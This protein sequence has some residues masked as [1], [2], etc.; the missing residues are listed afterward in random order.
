MLIGY[1]RCSSHDQVDG[2]TLAEQERMIRGVAM[3][4]G[5][6]QYDLTFYSDPAV[7]GGIS[8][9]NR[10]QGA[11][12]IANLKQGDI[13]IAAKLDRLFRS[14][15]DACY[16]VEYLKERGVGLILAD[17]GHMPVTESLTAK[18]FFQML[19]A[20]AEFERGRINERTQSGRDAKK[21][22]NGCVGAVPYGFRKTGKRRDSFLEENAT[23]QRNMRLMV[24]LRKQGLTYGEVASELA[25]KGIFNRAGLPFNRGQVFA[26]VSRNK[27]AE[28]PADV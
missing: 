27:Y 8:L 26:L 20:F 22:M 9:V 3:M 19:S 5:V 6:D 21:K 7:S 10:P 13:I 28:Q 14:V 16:I 2:T 23:E 18:L 4:R 12:L 1:T 17:M 25:A 15:K 11:E 24:A